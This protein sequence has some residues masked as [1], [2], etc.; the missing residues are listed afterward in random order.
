M[1]SKQ[2]LHARLT[3]IA[4]IAAA[5]GLAAALYVRQIMNGSYYA[6]KAEAQYVKPAAALF[7]RGTIFF[8][9]KDGTKASAATVGSGYLI[10]MNPSLVTDAAREYDVLSRSVP[11]DRTAFMRAAGKQN[12]RYEEL[13]HRVDP[14]IAQAIPALGLAGIGITKETWRSY[15]GGGLAAQAIGLVGEDAASST[16]EGRYGLERAYESVLSRPGVSGGTSAFAGIFS[17]IRDSLLGGSSAEGDIVTT[18][19]PTVEGQV[20]KI[21]AATAAEWHPD[22]IGGIVMDP[23][24]GE[25]VALASLPSYDPNNTAAVKS[26]SI[27]SDPLVEHVY[28]MGSIMKPLTM[29]TGLDSGAIRPAST[30]EDTGCMTLDT[31]KICNFDGKARGTTD[32]QTVL[33]QS[34]N[35]GAATI[36]LRTGAADMAKYFSSYGLGTKTGIDQPNE[37]TGILGDLK[38]G[39]DIDIATASYGQGIAVSPIEMARALSVLANGGYLVTPHLVKEIDYA[40]GSIK[41]IKPEKSG[42]LLKQDTSTEV[43]RMLVNVVDTALAK[44]AIKRDHYTVA[45]KTGT[46][47]MPDHVNGGYYGDRYLHSFFGFFPAY[48]P[49]YIVFLYQLYPKGAQYASETLTKP[50]DEI[51]KLLIN[52]YNIAPD[53]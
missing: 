15:P 31:K 19:E 14:A 29:A 26:A 47:E 4:I 1:N 18:I 43:T 34:L 44:G 48:Q 12:D 5:T 49:K 13:A 45:A 10:Y 16:V 17:D 52:Y 40:D 24:T 6:A 51:T 38:N 9:A 27:F 53:R 8:E 11:I 42:P 35:M 22:E 21:L 3:L 36:A 33:S 25:I 2:R 41:M 39:K 7:D 32:M 28:E 46:A 50:F 20:E 23:S 30:Y 37:A